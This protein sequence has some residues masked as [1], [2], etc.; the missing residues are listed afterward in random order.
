MLPFQI[1]PAFKA[2]AFKVCIQGVRQT[3]GFG[4][5]SPLFLELYIYHRYWQFKTEPLGHS[6]GAVDDQLIAESN[7]G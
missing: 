3:L 4:E 1:D 2:E 7:C 6:S 5:S